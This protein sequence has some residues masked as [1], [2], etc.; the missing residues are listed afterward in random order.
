MAAHLQGARDDKRVRGFLALTTFPA[1]LSRG[2]A[3]TNLAAVG[4]DAFTLHE[5][6]GHSSITIA[7][8]YVIRRPM[9]SSGHSQKVTCAAHLQGA[10]VTTRE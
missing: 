2:S 5:S 10:Q 8:R 1:V 6:G 3:L 9:L 4:C 7:Q